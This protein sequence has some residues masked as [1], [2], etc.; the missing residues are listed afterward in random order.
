VGLILTSM[1]K[2]D[3]SYHSLEMNACRD[4]GVFYILLALALRSTQSRTE[5]STRNLPGGKGRTVR[6]GD[7]FTAIC[8]PNVYK[9]MGASTSRNPRGSMACYRN[10]FWDN[11]AVCVKR[12][13]MRVVFISLPFL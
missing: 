11:T 13:S 8:E 3:I 1:S 5:M 9:N 12:R 6:R 7:T 4:M 10:S 2:T